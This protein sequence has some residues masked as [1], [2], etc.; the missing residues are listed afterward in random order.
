MF[1][2][3]DYNVNYISMNLREYEI[4]F[5]ENKNK[6]Q[7]LKTLTIL[8]EDVKNITEINGKDE[9]ST[10]TFECEE[11][12]GI[13]MMKY[14]EKSREDD[15]DF[16]YK[17][18]DIYSRFEANYLDSV[19]TILN[20]HNLPDS[21]FSIF[22]NTPDNYKIMGDFYDNGKIKIDMKIDFFNL[23]DDASP[24]LIGWKSLSK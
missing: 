5:D 17:L 13:A 8:F 10:F 15:E 9:G 22:P 7:V 6:D 21:Q 1:L 18:V 2:K 14:D 12:E 19:E 23:E 20:N 3:Q 4:G 16:F 24:F 11:E